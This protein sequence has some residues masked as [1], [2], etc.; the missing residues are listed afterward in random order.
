MI[1]T[2]TPARAFDKVALD[3]LG[4][5]PTTPQ[6]NTNVLTMQ[7][8]LT[9]Y[10]IYASLKDARAETTASTLQSIISFVVSVVRKAF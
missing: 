7:D 5:F 4:P 6:G 2:D 8:L 3:I 1:I 9:K 10:S